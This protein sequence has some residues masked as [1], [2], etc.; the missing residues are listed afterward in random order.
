M[1]AVSGGARSIV[2]SHRVSRHRTAAKVKAID[3]YGLPASGPTTINTADI[4][5]RAG[6]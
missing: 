2:G 3:R 1:P 6:G 5:K 4:M